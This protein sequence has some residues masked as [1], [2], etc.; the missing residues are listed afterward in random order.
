MPAASGQ[1]E[2][3]SLEI[4]N[5]GTDPARRLRPEGISPAK[6]TLAHMRTLYPVQPSHIC[7]TAVTPY[8]PKFL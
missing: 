8:A 1:V 2:H 4:I 3:A 7:V 6:P 5:K